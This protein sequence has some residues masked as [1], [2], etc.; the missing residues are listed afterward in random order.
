M[1]THTRHKNKRVQL[2]RTRLNRKVIFWIKHYSTCEF[3][4]MDNKI[5]KSTVN[6]LANSLRKT[7]LVFFEKSG[8]T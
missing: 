5:N 8:V 1:Y 7:F 3:E 6:R 2:L 4:K